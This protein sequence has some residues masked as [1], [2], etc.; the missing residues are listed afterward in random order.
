MKGYGC[1]VFMLVY[2][3]S[4]WMD[5]GGNTYPIEGYIEAK[6]FTRDI[7]IRYGLYGIL[8]GKIDYL[9]Y[10]RIKDGHWLVVKTELSEDLIKTDYYNGH[11]KF[12]N[13]FV[14]Y[15]GNIRSAAKFILNN[16]DNPQELLHKDAAWLQPEE[17]AGSEIWMKEHR[18]ELAY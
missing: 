1:Y 7:D 10:E 5:I 6:E 2:V 14:V 8:W 13:G 17:V 15:A 12:K 11:Y 4:E 9:S 18:L 3:D 16:K